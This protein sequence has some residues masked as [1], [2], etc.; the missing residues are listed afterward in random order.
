MEVV[1]GWEPPGLCVPFPQT[2]WFGGRHSYCEHSISKVTKEGKIREIMQRL[3][4]HCKRLIALLIN[5]LEPGFRLFTA[6]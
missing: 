3:C 5:I 2:D 1:G 6:W 4:L